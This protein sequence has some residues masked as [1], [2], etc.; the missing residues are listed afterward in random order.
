M[1]DFT[2]LFP[3]E[4]RHIWQRATQKGQKIQEIRLRVNKPV[5]V[6]SDGV[7]YFVS[8][9]G[10]LKNQTENPLILGKEEVWSIF[11]HICQ[12]SIYAYEEEIKKGY[13]TAVGGHRIGLVGTAVLEDSHCVKSIKQISG[14]NIRIAHEIKGVADSILPFL[15]KQGQVKNTLIISPP[16]CGKTTLLRDIIRQISNG[17]PY[18]VGRSVGV[19]DERSEL[20]GMFQGEAQNDLG[21]RTDVLDACPKVIGMEML[22]RSMNPRVLAVDELGGYEDLEMVSRATTCGVS[23]IAT[24][25][26][27]GLE[28]YE[29]KYG[30]GGLAKT[31]I[32]QCF[33]ILGR[34][35]NHFFIKEKYEVT[36]DATERVGLLDDHKRKCGIGS[37]VSRTNIIANSDFEE[38]KLDNGAFK[39]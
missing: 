36:G 31:P 34:E 13:V 27:Y 3:K 8:P 26:G 6:M 29:K 18:G 35:E 37:M 25:H 24:I 11:S 14:L 12:H 9:V 32:F 19:V 4:Q 7:E 22:I 23:V 33:L 28:D 20:A 38:I 17:N 15:Y 16:A 2:Y 1:K 30:N 21:I 10:E 5:I 39:Q